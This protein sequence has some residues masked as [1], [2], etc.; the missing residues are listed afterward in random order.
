MNAPTLPWPINAT[1]KGSINSDDFTLHGA[2]V[3]RTFGVYDAIL[4]FSRI[5]RHFHPSAMGTFIVSASCGA[6]A[7]SRNDGLNFSQMGVQS[8]QLMRKIDVA[9]G[10][11]TITG[12]A[13][14]LAQALTLALEIEG[15]VDLPDDLAGHSVYLKKVSAHSPSCIKAVGE[16]SLFRL[17]G[18]EVPVDVNSRYDLLPDPLPN[19][20]A[21]PEYRYATEDG[22]VTGNSYHL[23]IHSIFD[24]KNVGNALA[25]RCCNL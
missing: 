8:Y 16:G 23:R 11:I 15:K 22:I 5:P 18:S 13:K 9:G 2:G 7:A 14:Y 24:G 25:D 1:A 21:N 17:N 4:N 6:G 20:I 12:T 3:I 10:T 19:I